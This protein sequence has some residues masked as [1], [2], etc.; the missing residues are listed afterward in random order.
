MIE[1]VQL[2]PL[3]HIKVPKGDIYHI[4]KSTDESFCGFGEVY[5]SEIEPKEIKGWKRHNRMTLN[6]IVVNGEIGFVVYDDRIGSKTY[7][8]FETFVLSRANNYQ[9]LTVAPGLWMAFWGAS[10][11]VSMLMDIIPEV[12][13]PCE[14]DRCDINQIPYQ[15]P[16][17]S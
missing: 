15:F 11:E 2:T 16:C 7:G 13:D 14:A 1:G 9:R 3:K 4:L 10:E 5:F 17:E 6:L 8:Q 12:H